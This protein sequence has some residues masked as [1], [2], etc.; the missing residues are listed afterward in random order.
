MANEDL[1]KEIELLRKQ[2]EAM[3]SE[4]EAQQAAA[5]PDTGEQPAIAEESI[6]A[7]GATAADRTEDLIVQ[8]KDLLDSIDKDIKDAKPTTLL[9]VFALGVLVGRL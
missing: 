8:F 3:K 2:L 6:S 4:R 9:I 1:Q 5:I 7:S